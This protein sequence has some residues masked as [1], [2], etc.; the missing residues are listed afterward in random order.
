MVNKRETN[1]KH[2]TRNTTQKTKA[3]ITR[4]LQ[5]LGRVSSCGPEGLASVTRSVTQ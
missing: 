5:K 4:T 1:D 3:R 2:R